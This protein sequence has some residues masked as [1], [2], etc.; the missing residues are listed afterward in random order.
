MA[1]IWRMELIIALIAGLILLWCG[2]KIVKF[3][4][5]LIVWGLAV[6]ILLS[7]LCHYFEVFKPTP[8]KKK[9]PARTS[10]LPVGLFCYPYKGYNFRRQ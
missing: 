8:L 2:Y 7:A 5:K 1:T 6:L 3:V 10:L 4:T 9:Q